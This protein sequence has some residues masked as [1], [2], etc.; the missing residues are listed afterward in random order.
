MRLSFHVMLL[1][2]AV[3]C[4]SVTKTAH[5]I[6]PKIAIS[7]TTKSEQ[8][9]IL[10]AGS[11]STSVYSLISIDRMLARREP[12]RIQLGYSKQGRAV[13]AWYFPGQTDHR[14]LVIGGVHGSELSSIEVANAL[15]AELLAA[16]ELPY[17]TVIVVPSLFPDNAAIA[18]NFPEEAGS[19][20]NIGRYSGDNA[21][22]PNRQMPSP[23]KAFDEAHQRDHL[24]RMI[25]RENQFLLQLIQSYEPARITNVHAIRNTGYGGIYADPRTDHLGVALGYES[26]SS[27]AVM[28]A[29]YVE[30]NGGNVKGNRLGIKPTALYYKDPVPVNAG[31]FQPRN[32][33]GSSLKAHRGSGVSLGTWGTTAVNG[34]EF[35]RPAMRVITMEFPGAKRPM[36][37]LHEKERRAVRAQVEIFARSIF[38]VFLQNHMVENTPD[39]E[40]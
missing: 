2:V 32:M 5:H 38:E 37:Y 22:D 3:L 10:F 39:Q 6:E 11:K 17:Y 19:V 31:I 29:Q 33:S 40:M 35:N 36:D 25:E 23:G 21:V 18:A 8:A 15:I 24:D 28:M 26:D 14:A 4:M 9:T 16:D 12:A 20:K 30:K 13:Q 1:L 34:Q 7:D 27:L